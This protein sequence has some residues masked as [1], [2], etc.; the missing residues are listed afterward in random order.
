MTPDA[1]TPRFSICIPFYKGLDTIE[2]CLSS[3]RGQLAVD[4][5]AVEIVIANDNGDDA[6]I[7]AELAAH[8]VQYGAVLHHNPQR[9]GL[10]G[11]W[12]RALSLGAGDIR[13]LLGQDDWLHPQCLAHVNGLFAQLDDPLFVTVSEL[14]FAKQNTHVA[15]QKRALLGT[16]AAE[17]FLQRLLT[18]TDGPTPGSVFIDS[19]YL[20]E[21]P[22][23]TERFV[24]CPE[25]ELY[26]RLCASHPQRRVLGSDA[27]LLNRG[28]HGLN[29]GGARHYDQ[30]VLDYCTLVLDHRQ[31]L[32]FDALGRKPELCGFGG[33]IGVLERIIIGLN[34]LAPDEHAMR[35]RQIQRV[36]T[37]EPFNALLH[38]D[39][40]VPT[41]LGRRMVHLCREFTHLPI[42][43]LFA[44]IL[45]MPGAPRD[46]LSTVLHRCRTAG[47]VR[48]IPVTAPPPPPLPGS[49]REKLGRLFGA[50]RAS[51]ATGTPTI[52]QQPVKRAKPQRI[53]APDD[54]LQRTATAQP[55]LICG[56]HHSGTRLIAQRL[57]AMGVFQV[58]GAHTHEWQ[59]VQ[60][61]NMLLL[62]RWN[63][64]EAV[65]AFDPAGQPYRIDAD[66]VARRLWRHGYD[67]D[68]PW[69]HKDPRTVATIDA[70]LAAF[71]EARILHVVRD[72]ADVLGTLPA[73]YAPYTPAGQLPQDNLPFWAA[74]WQA[75]AE[76][77][78]RAVDGHSHSVEIRFEDLCRQPRETLGRIAKAFRLNR[79]LPVDIDA[80]INTAKIGI[81]RQWI[82]DGRLDAAALEGIL[83]QLTDLRAVY[84]YD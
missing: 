30:R 36:L 58:A 43:E 74:L 44:G 12:S 35:V 14:R 7:S 19:R 18:F 84:G 45:D 29:Y 48:E 9:L 73:T 80:D 83:E 15:V 16:H 3:I 77:M 76:T 81:H 57:S 51:T 5:N 33:I 42:V 6:S 78:R 17:T 4:P 23:Y 59:A 8:A 60:Q 41:H 49:R 67:G 37:S 65:R 34:D 56:F 61:L 22:L 69:G 1:A 53:T 11:N 27:F 47:L 70:W 24:Y 28:A 10:A 72:P 54:M 38:L 63:D 52:V 2:R 31:H 62:P 64:A 25:I 66:D 26:A 68:T 21:A 55:I 79:T 46:V 39:D 75:G 40:A 32:D 20:P 82:E 71:P 13:T 50:S